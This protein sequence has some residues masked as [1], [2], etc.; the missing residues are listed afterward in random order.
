MKHFIC[1][2]TLSL[3]LINPSFA[4]HGK[5]HDHS[6]D[7]NSE[8]LSN[9]KKVASADCK[10]KVNIDVNG[11]VCD[12]CARAVEKVFSKR[13]EVS[14]ID[15]NLDKGKI[16]IA[17]KDGKSIDNTTLTKLITDSGYDVVKINKDCDE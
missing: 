2:L 8:V 6:K 5:N 15:V 4:S 7:M 11:L 16:V 14:A 13:E 9:A 3:L 12:F 17:M 1:F 10:N